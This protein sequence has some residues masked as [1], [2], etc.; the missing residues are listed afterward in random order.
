MDDRVAEMDELN[1]SECFGL[2]ARGRVGRLG[3]L[4][5][6]GPEILPVNYA[7]DG[8]SVLFRTSAESVLNRAAGQVVAFEVDEVDPSDGSGWS[9]LVKGRA[10]DIGDAVDAT[11]ERLRALALPTWAPGQRDRWFHLVPDK[12]T[13]RR[14]RAVSPEL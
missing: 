2:L 10:Q 7:I 5:D 1:P 8:E 11:S 4:V 6:D 9:V 12:V 3:L 13:G 14:L